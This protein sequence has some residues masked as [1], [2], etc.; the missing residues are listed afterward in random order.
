MNTTTPTSTGSAGAF[1]ALL[2]TCVSPTQMS[3]MKVMSSS[4]SH[5]KYR[6]SPAL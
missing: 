2:S 6:V 5:P 4:D 1:S 3:T